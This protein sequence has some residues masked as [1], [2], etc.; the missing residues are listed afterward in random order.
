[1]LHV[2]MRYYRLGGEPSPDF[3]RAFCAAILEAKGKVCEVC[4]LERLG[5]VPDYRQAGYP[6]HPWTPVDKPQ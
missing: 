2:P 5:H 6:D 3:V 4:G 1:M